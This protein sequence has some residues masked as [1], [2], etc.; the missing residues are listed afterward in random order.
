MS[1]KNERSGLKKLFSL[2]LKAPGGQPYAVL[3]CMVLASVLE[4][5]G[6]GALVPLAAQISQNDAGAQSFLARFFDQI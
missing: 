4:I 2:F 3:L 1:V 6:M 5:I